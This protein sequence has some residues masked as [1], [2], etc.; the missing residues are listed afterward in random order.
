M[1]MQGHTVEIR[2]VHGESQKFECVLAWVEA[3][4]FGKGELAL[5]SNSAPCARTPVTATSKLLQQLFF[6]SLHGNTSRG[7]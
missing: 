5:K 7:V 6:G 4:L 1:Q 2:E 3:E